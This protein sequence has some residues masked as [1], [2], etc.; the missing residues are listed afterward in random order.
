[1]EYGYPML[2]SEKIKGNE[3]FISDCGSPITEEYYLKCLNQDVYTLT[4]ISLLYNVPAYNEDIH[5]E[6]LCVNF[7]DKL[8]EYKWSIKINQDLF[9]VTWKCNGIITIID[10]DSI[11]YKKN[12]SKMEIVDDII[13]IPDIPHLNKNFITGI[14]CYRDGGAILLLSKITKFISNENY[15]IRYTTLT[16]PPIQPVSSVLE[17]YP[18]EEISTS[19]CCSIDPIKNGKY[20]KNLTSIMQYYAKNIAKIHGYTEEHGKVFT[21]LAQEFDKLFNPVVIPSDTGL[22]YLGYDSVLLSTTE[23]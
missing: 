4:L 2:L 17:V 16:K 15:N 22:V 3:Y 6:I 23:I 14:L 20:L 9:E 1:M 8:F 13:N 12:K 10:W 11:Q 18:S 7:P 19:S 5:L 21:D